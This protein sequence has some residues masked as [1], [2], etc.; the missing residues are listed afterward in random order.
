MPHPSQ[1]LVRAIRTCHALAAKA[2]V[3][4]ASAVNYVPDLYK[5]LS[6]LQAICVVPYG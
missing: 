4:V 5:W 2:S 6:V 1:A 3:P